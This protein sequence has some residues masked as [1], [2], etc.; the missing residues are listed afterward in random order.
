MS[1]CSKMK[2]VI[3]KQRNSCKALELRSATTRLK[4]FSL[5]WCDDISPDISP[6]INFLYFTFEKTQ[7][8]PSVKLNIV[9]VYF[10]F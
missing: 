1:G 5:H 3:L 9:T 4:Q 2:G 8:T 6:L 7:V 10:A